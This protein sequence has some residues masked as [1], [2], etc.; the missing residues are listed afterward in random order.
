MSVR[1]TYFLLVALLNFF[2]LANAN[3]NDNTFPFT[4]VVDILSDNVEFSTF[5]RKVQRNGYVPYLNELQ[6]FTLL[7]PVNSAFLANGK[8]DDTIFDIENYLLHDLILETSSTDGILVISES[9]KFPFVFENLQD[10]GAAPIINGVSIVDPDLKPNFQNA[11]VQ[12][13]S[14]FIKTPPGPLGLLADLDATNLYSSGEYVTF[15]YIKKLATQCYTIFEELAQNNTLLIPADNTFYEYFNKIEIN[16]LLDYFNQMKNVRQQVQES[17]QWDRMKFLKSTITKSII[18]GTIKEGIQ[19]YNLNKEPILFKSANVTSIMVNNSSISTDSN[20]V[21]DN[22]LAHSFKML[23]LVSNII[24]FD[25]EKYLHGLNNSK[26]VQELYFRDLQH[27]IGKQTAEN[28]NITIFVP[29]PSTNDDTTFTKS[30]I[31]YHFVNEHIWLENLG[32]SNTHLFKSYFCSSNKR[33]GGNCQMLKISSTVDGFRINEKVKILNPKPYK[34][35]NTLIYTISEDVSLPGDLLLSLPPFYHCSISL[36]FMRQLNLLNLAPNHK[37]YTIFLPC[38]DAWNVMDLNL[39]YLERN[40]SAINI[41]IKNYILNDLFYSNNLSYANVKTTNFLGQ[42]LTVSARS[43]VDTSKIVELDLD[44][45]DTPFKVESGMDILFD[46]GV[47]HPL[48]DISFPKELNITLIDLIKTTQSGDFLDMIEKFD[49]LRSIVSGD[50]AF[51]I[52]V[53]TRA[54][55]FREGINLNS[56]SLKDFLETHF[57][58]GN[59]TR[60]LL[61]CN[62]QITTKSGKHLTCQ[63]M[64]RE[65]YL[66]K[67]QDINDHELRI[68]RKGCST[69]NNDSCIFLIDRPISLKWF[70]QEK[71]YLK[72]P[73]VAIGVGIMLGALLTSALCFV[74]ILPIGKRYRSKRD[75]IGS[76]SQ[77]LLARGSENTVQYDSCLLY[78]SRCV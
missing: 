28:A 43:N 69:I 6:N 44:T 30:M 66:L 39:A 64:S 56:T 16:Y 61:Q 42:N 26:F 19:G 5:L 34:I 45:F 37:G 55:L 49:D 20:L 32:S 27:L 31:L 60:N 23:D 51:S 76:S 36:D 40:I 72:L 65:N 52:M 13:I 62:G 54:S 4:T 67:F 7:A 11:T 33:L 18:G 50:A 8:D 9:V 57:I 68:L 73:G 74:L 12:G 75:D 48:R 15:Q 38:F 58:L 1:V 22:G 24:E 14:G 21:F 17:W 3:N 71:Y 46:K 70:E 10:E 41:M 63:E 47:I 78:T 59:S 53:P 2:T 25:A 77:A 35:G 29:D